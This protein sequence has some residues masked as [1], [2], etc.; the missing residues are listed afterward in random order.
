[1]LSDCPGL[2]NPANGQVDATT[3]VSTGQTATYTCDGGYSMIGSDTRIC[4]G[5]GTWSGSEPVCGSKF[6]RN[7]WACNIHFIYAFYFC[8][9]LFFRAQKFVINS[10]LENALRQL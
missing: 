2:S 5:D 7:I 10:F 6:T 3:A 8:F 9:V 4:Q 1:M